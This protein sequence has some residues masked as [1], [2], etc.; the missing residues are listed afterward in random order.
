MSAASGE[1]GPDAAAL[2]ASGRTA[3]AP[4]AVIRFEHGSRVPGWDEAADLEKD[5]EVRK[6]YLGVH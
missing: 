6:A 2:G 3:G 1:L 5:P 4:V